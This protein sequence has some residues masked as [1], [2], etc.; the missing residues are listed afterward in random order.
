[1]VNV[2]SPLWVAFRRGEG[3]GHLTINNLTAKGVGRTPFFVAGTADNPMRSLVLNNVRITFAGEGAEEQADRVGPSPYSMLESYGFLCRY[4][5]NF[6]LRGVRVGYAKKDLRPALVAENVANLQLDGFVAEREP[7]G[8]P[9]YRLSGVQQVELDGKPAP[10]TNARIAALNAESA[11]VTVDTPFSAAVKAENTG[12]QGLA[13]VRLQIGDR[14]ITESVWLKER[15]VASVTFHNLRCGRVG[16]CRLRAGEREQV[17]TVRAK[18]QGHPVTAPYTAFHNTNAQLVQYEGGDFY[19]RAGGDM[20]LVDRADQYGAVYLKNGLPQNGVVIVRLENP[21]LR[22]HWAGRAGIIV[23]NDI[24]KP[25]QS[26]GYLV[27]GASPANG[28][29]MEWDSDGD[30]HIDRHTE[31]DGYTYWPNWLK[32]E[33]KGNKFTGFSSTDGKNWSLVGEVEVPGAAETE[34]TGVFAHLS[35]ARFSNLKVS[36]VAGQ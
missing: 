19:I 8:A 21:D 14:S 15:E 3:L 27:L 26:K 5:E 13:E 25:G 31:F 1:M 35:S 6:E 18:P 9:P 24:S 29:C 34:D 32:L 10:R 23:R 7:D 16:E 33:R 12:T 28:Y 22:G 11:N 4:I 30:G 20:A 2:R 17:L 36:Q